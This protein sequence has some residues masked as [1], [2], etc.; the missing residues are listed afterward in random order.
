LSISVI[1]GFWVFTQ[2]NADTVDWDDYSIYT[3]YDK[4]DEELLIKFTAFSDGD[5]DEEFT[6]EMD[7]DDKTCDIDLEY[8]KFQVI[9]ECSLNMD[10]D[11][12]RGIYDT[13]FVIYDDEN[14]DVFNEDVEV[15]IDGY[16][17]ELDWDKLR[18]EAIY[19]EEDEDLDL[20][21]Y[22]EDLSRSPDYEYEIE[23]E[24]N[25]RNFLEDF[26]YNDDEQEL[27]VILDIS[28]DE[29]DIRDEYEIEYEI[30][31]KDL[32]DEEVADS[33][34]DFDVD[35]VSEDDNFDWD[36]IDV[37]AVYDEDSERLNIT[38]TL[39][40]IVVE[41][42]KDYESFVEL[43]GEDY[44][45]R[46]K[47]DDDT[48]ELV[49]EYSIKI[50]EDDIV[51]SYDIELIIEDDDSEEVYDE[52]IDIDVELLS[53]VN[54]FDWDD[55]EV[56]AMY[57]EDSERLYVE[58]VLE[59]VSARPT[60][61][62]SVEI[63]F[64]DE[65]DTTDFSYDSGRDELT[66]NFDFKID[67]DD[68][69][70]EYEFE[71]TI[72]DEDGER[73]FREDIESDVED[74]EE[75]DDEDVTVSSNST[76]NWENAEILFDYDTQS[77]YLTI[78]IELDDVVDYP[79]LDYYVDIT[80]SPFGKLWSKLRYDSQQ[81]IL[82]G[83]YE[84]FVNQADIEDSYNITVFINDEDDNLEYFI[85]DEYDVVRDRDE[86]EEE[87]SED[88]ISLSIKAAVERFIDRTYNRFDDESDAI[89]YFERV[90]PALD[91]YA[92]QRTQYRSV[93]DDINYLI[94]E[95]IN[96]KS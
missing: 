73:V 65:D 60:L 59:D 18:A 49:A 55:L 13:E 79:S 94:Q 81:D 40:D 31:N 82:Y 58:L 23:F 93:V 64:E 11:E 52:D 69:E 38:I 27:S 28:I 74:F 14:E 10:L 75:E 41:P 6:F 34:L 57:K 53:E 96:S 15:E 51:N 90:I 61:D 30:F 36:D 86:S 37:V 33:E 19:D 32:D 35:I 22:L 7:L 80:I 44:D 72:E 21:L 68:I 42:K 24:I 95:E 12:V 71:I 56:T 16:S 62:F 76:Y 92:T 46:F 66:A 87:E 91:A 43:D 45:E 88:G 1:L 89:D 63:E 78:R 83:V 84:I 9:W 25:D 70:N 17:E 5:P 77:Q 29:N 50:D 3:D 48:E 85:T 47:Y 67:E 39:S 20:K 2:V 8:R 54:N 26:S 4:N